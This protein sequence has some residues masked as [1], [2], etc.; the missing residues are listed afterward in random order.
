MFTIG[1]R[2]SVRI[3]AEIA[4]LDDAVD[5]LDNA[6]AQHYVYLAARLSKKTFGFHSSLG[7]DDGATFPD[8]YGPSG[9]DPE[10]VIRASPATLHEIYGPQHDGP[11]ASEFAAANSPRALLRWQQSG[12]KS[13]WPKAGATVQSCRP[14]T[15]TG[16]TPMRP[17]AKDEEHRRQRA[18]GGYCCDKHAARGPRVDKLT[19][20]SGP[21][22]QNADNAPE[23]SPATAAQAS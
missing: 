17:T 19:G 7:P 21:W 12:G 18:D 13:W 23:T 15:P 6:E 11:H 20:R 14:F 22:L 1:Y 16:R 8:I 9:V 2:D 4:A 3:E 5:P 10:A